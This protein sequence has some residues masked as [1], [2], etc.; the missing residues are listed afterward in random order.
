MLANYEKRS[1]ATATRAAICVT[2]VVVTVAFI[3]CFVVDPL[4][5]WNNDLKWPISAAAIA[6]TWSSTYAAFLVQFMGS[7]NPVIAISGV[8]VSWLVAT[9]QVMCRPDVLAAFGRAVTC[10][11][12]AGG[13]AAVICYAIMLSGAEIIDTR[14]HVDGMRLLR[15]KEGVAHLRAVIS[16]ESGSGKSAL[17]IA[18]RFV[19][20]RLRE[21]RGIFDRGRHRQ[22]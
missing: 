16:R 11:I 22:R 20:S 9:V 10:A 1:N 12:A 13:P 21:L 2:V 18:P 4:T 3:M 19:I 6:A 15:G 5:I 8:V 17:K 7:G 14:Q